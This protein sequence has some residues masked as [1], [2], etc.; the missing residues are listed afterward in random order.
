MAMNEM[1]GGRMPG[2]WLFGLLTLFSSCSL[3]LRSSNIWGGRSVGIVERRSSQSTADERRN[4][5]NFP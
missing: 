5:S 3:S 4:Q 2:M 1:M